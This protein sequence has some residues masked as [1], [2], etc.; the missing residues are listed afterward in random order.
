MTVDAIIQSL[1]K[2]LN[3]NI[4]SWVLQGFIAYLAILWIAIIIW[5]TKD[6]NN[7]SN[8][9]MFQI[10]A[11][12]VVII[13]TPIFGL[14]IYLIVRP[15]KTLTEKY[16][17]QSQMHL[18]NEEEQKEKKE[19][20]DTCGNLADP[21]HIFCGSCGTKIKKRCSHCKEAYKHSFA[22]CP[23][24]GK[25]EKEKAKGKLQVEEDDEEENEMKENA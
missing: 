7:R 22:L 16:L 2:L 8:S 11:I 6:A 13:L 18:L 19:K 23:F 3:S 10:F 9:L 17:E 1:E 25:K 12:L 5:V 14:L 15:S 24:C 20:C 21:D 4:V